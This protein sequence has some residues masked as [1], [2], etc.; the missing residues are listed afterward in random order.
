MARELLIGGEPARLIY[1]TI[2]RFPMSILPDGR[3]ELHNNATGQAAEA[4]AR[5]YAIVEMEVLTGIERCPC[6]EEHEPMDAD[7][8]RMMVIHAMADDARV[9]LGERRPHPLWC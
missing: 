5:A 3:I 8:Y 9:L 2:E 6:P 4:F 1:D 7:E